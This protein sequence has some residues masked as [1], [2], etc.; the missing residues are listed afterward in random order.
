MTH[1]QH[2]PFEELADAVEEAAEAAVECTEEAKAERAKRSVPKYYVVQELAY[3]CNTPAQVN[4]YFRDNYKE[5]MSVIKGFHSV[6]RRK[7]TYEF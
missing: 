7:E 4:D 3:A 6:P 2:D 5:G 1:K